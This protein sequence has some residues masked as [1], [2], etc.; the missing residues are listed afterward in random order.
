MVD[1][2]GRGAMPTLRIIIVNWRSG[3]VLRQCLRSIESASADQHVLREVCIVDND[4][5]DGSMEGIR[6]L[7]LPLRVIR[8]RKNVGFA[9]ACN[10]GAEGADTDFLL[11]LNPDVLL[12]PDTLDRSIEGFMNNDDGSLA[13]LGV[14]LTDEKGCIARSCSRRPTVS[15]V[16]NISVGLT[17][18]LPSRF[19]G[20]FMLEWDHRE[21]RVVEQVM[22][23]FFLVQRRTYEFLEGF[24]NR[25][26]MYYEEVD[27]CH[28]ARMIGKHVL[29]FAGACAIHYGR[30]SSDQ[31]K[32]ERLQYVLTSRLKYFKKHQPGCRFWFVLGCSL[33]L[34]PISRIIH[35]LFCGRGQEIRDTL[36]AYRNLLPEL[37][38]IATY[39]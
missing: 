35:S 5:S 17:K 7:N 14:Q 19:K 28:K 12:K 21:N 22:G 36:K 8:N 39:E 15:T 1:V 18:V 31:I 4:S 32:A 10:Q 16:F 34:E 26:F 13:V 33:L 38:D 20:Q 30:V 37:K 24:D 11:F 2:R 29:Y 23:A 6:K 25:Y 3:E 27:F 9:R